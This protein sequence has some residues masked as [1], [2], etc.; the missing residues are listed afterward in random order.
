M[1]TLKKCRIA[2]YDKSIKEP[3]FLTI[4][5]DEVEVEEPD[6]NMDDLGSRFSRN[7]HVACA[8]KG[9]TMQFYTTSDEEGFDYK[10]V[11]YNN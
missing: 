2:K 11:V 4:P 1:G 8:K 6:D 10:I 7:L 5:L 9:Y 3:P